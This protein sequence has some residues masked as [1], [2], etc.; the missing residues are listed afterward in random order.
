MPVVHGPS[1][2]SRQLA[3]LR[4][5][6]SAVVPSG[7]PFPLGADD[8]DTAGRLAGYLSR[9]PAPEPT[10]QTSAV[11]STRPWTSG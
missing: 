3:T 9:L 4:A 6:A 2:T 7:G 10:T 1:L 5:L 11:T 8:V